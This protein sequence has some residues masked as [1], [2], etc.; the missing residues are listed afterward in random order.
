MNRTESR[1]EWPVVVLEVDY[2]DCKN[3]MLDN[4]RVDAVKFNTIVARTKAGRCWDEWNELT[5]DRI[6]EQRLELCQ[7]S[8]D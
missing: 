1:W 4:K 8:F 2:R 7:S 6:D 3:E 5:M